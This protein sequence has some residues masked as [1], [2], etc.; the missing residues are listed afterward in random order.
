MSTHY[1]LHAANIDPRYRFCR[2]SKLLTHQYQHQ[3][4]NSLTNTELQ[5]PTLPFQPA[6]ADLPL[7]SSDRR[8]LDLFPFPFP[9][10]LSLHLWFFLFFWSVDLASSSSFFFFFPVWLIRKWRKW[11]TFWMK[12]IF[13]YVCVYVLIWIWVLILNFLDLC[14][15][16]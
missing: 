7:A 14:S 8:R 10:L 6:D 13:Y 2:P 12:W 1:P 11:W 5:N 4:T 16:F 9:S 3:S 15:C